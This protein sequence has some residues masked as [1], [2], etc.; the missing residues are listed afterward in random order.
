MSKA[1]SYALFVE[2]PVNATGNELKTFVALW[3]EYLTALSSVLPV[4]VVPIQKTHLV[5]MIRA[6]RG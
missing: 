4:I 6:H 5:A 1:I 3:T 2:G